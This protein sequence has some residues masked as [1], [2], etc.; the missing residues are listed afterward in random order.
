MSIVGLADDKRR[1]EK[2]TYWDDV[3]GMKSIENDVMCTF[4][5]NKSV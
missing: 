2:L 4:T 3:Y 5:M 1:K